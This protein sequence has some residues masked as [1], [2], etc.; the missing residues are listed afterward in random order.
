MHTLF[1]SYGGKKFDSLASI[2]YTKYI[3]MVTTSNVVEPDNL[4]PTERARYYHALRVHLQVYDVFYL[5]NKIMTIHITDVDDITNTV[6]IPFLIY[7]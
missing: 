4:P 7:S 3:E 6:F 1:S 5:F 2:R